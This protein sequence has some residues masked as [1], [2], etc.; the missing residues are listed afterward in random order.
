MSSSSLLLQIR[1]R[2]HIETD[3]IEDSIA[4]AEVDDIEG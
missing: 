3:Q 1:K 4:D 2:N